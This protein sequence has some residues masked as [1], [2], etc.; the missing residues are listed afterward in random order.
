MG[1][2]PFC[3][4]EISED[5]VLYGGAC[6]GCLIDIPGEE[7][8]TDPG[9]TTSTEG[10]SAQTVAQNSKDLPTRTLV[11]AGVLC[12]VM[13]IGIG[14]L[15]S[16][17]SGGPGTV[18]EYDQ[19]EEQHENLEAEAPAEFAENP[20]TPEPVADPSE[21]V[22]EIEVVAQTGQR[23]RSRG[24]RAG[25]EVEEEESSFET[26]VVEG[27]LGAS[28]V[29]VSR[30]TSIDAGAVRGAQVTTYIS[31]ARSRMD[32][33]FKAC[34][35]EKAKG[36][37]GNV[38]LSYTVQTDGSVTELSL[39][40]SSSL[41]DPGLRSCFDDHALGLKFPEFAATQPVSETFSY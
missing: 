28:V 20:V 21:T 13:V 41:S 38:R 40:T 1:E 31:S 4:A 33:K 10:I 15:V 14:L 23:S 11:L 9:E 7:A 35:E 22:A 16:R 25:S 18:A 26:Q 32:K 39:S 30:D 19:S 34:I 2:C 17:Q 36:T 29:N 5:L 8:P 37:R 12:V 3:S 6:P 27:S 24:P